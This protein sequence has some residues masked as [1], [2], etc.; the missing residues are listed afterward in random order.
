[1]GEDSSKCLNNNRRFVENI[2]RYIVKYSK[3]NMR[4]KN[5]K[6][7]KTTKVVECKHKSTSKNKEAKI[8][9]I[10]AKKNK[11]ELHKLQNSKKKG[12]RHG[13]ESKKTKLGRI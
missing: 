7:T 8:E 6:Y 9:R 1:M 2:Q 13:D 3:G 11:R 10:L 5:R 12:Q 4:Y